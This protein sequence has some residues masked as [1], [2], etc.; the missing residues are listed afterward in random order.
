[1][2]DEI[3]LKRTY[4]NRRIIVSGSTSKKLPDKLI[5]SLARDFPYGEDS[6]LDEFLVSKISD[7]LSSH[8]VSLKLMDPQTAEKTRALG[9]EI[10][11]AEGES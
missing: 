3:T 6:Q 1:M 4:A 8:S 11:G 5:R 10:F 9:D 7:Y 2:I